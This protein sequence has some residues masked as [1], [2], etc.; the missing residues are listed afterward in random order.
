MNQAETIAWYGRL[1][2]AQKLALLLDLMQQLTIVVRSI[3]HDHAGEPATTSRLAYAIS[4][5]NHRLT[6]AASAVL[7][8]RPTLPDHALIGLFFDI[9]QHVELAQYLPFVLEQAIAR[10]DGSPD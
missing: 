6:S 3:F 1:T 7:H 5:L 4:E 2:K 8:N 9:P 10:L